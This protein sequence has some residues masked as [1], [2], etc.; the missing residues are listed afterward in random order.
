MLEKIEIKVPLQQ[1]DPAAPRYVVVPAA[2]IAAWNLERTT[3]VDIDVNDKP[4]G[5]RRLRKWDDSRWYI[6]FPQLV[7][8]DLSLAAGQAVRLGIRLAVHDLPTELLLLMAEHEDAR[9]R[10]DAL[11]EPEQRS[12]RSH[13]RLAQ[14][15]KTRWMR[16]AAELGVDAPVPGELMRESKRRREKP[17]LRVVLHPAPDNAESRQAWSEVLDLFADACADMILYKAW[18]EVTLE[19]GGDPANRDLVPHHLFDMWAAEYDPEFG[20]V[21]K[22]GSS[23]RQKL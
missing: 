21:R 22:K 1:D 17:P 9:V 3:E 4:G 14:L 19:S 23:R 10:W 15:P 16:A 12:I 18:K 5:R 11:P 7:C 13:V 20:K 2:V 6:E 8:K